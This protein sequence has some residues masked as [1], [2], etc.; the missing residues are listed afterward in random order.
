VIGNA[1][2]DDEQLPQLLEL[3]LPQASITQ[4]GMETYHIMYLYDAA[5]QNRWKLT[6]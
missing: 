6:I 4:L 1:I 5:I 2:D 3:S